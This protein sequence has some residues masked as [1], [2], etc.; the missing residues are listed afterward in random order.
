MKKNIYLILIILLSMMSTSGTAQTRIGGFPFFR[1]FLDGIMDEVE[2]PG[3]NN[4]TATPGVDRSNK[5]DLVKNLGLQL[6]TLKSR[7]I[8]SS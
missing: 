3:P 7:S 5:A 8:L 2:R 4:P 6:T 1:S